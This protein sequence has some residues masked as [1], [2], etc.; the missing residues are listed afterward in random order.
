MQAECQ[1]ANR[2]QK[3]YF[4][5]KLS[6]DKNSVKYKYSLYLLYKL[7]GENEKAQNQFAQIRK[8]K[9][10][11][12]S[13]YIDL[14]E[15]YFEEINLETAIK[16]LDHAIKK[17]PSEYEPYSEKMKLYFLSEEAEKL[18]ETTEKTQNIFN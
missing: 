15:V 9:P 2:G 8:I 6:L 4:S 18:K 7:K 1:K 5:K 17:F 3:R 12:L 10:E 16:T 13:D 11:K 14:S